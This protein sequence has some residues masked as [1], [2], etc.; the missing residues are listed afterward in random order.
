[1][2]NYDSSTQQYQPEGLGQNQEGEEVEFDEADVQGVSTLTKRATGFQRFMKFVL[3]IVGVVAVGCFAVWYLY[4]G[5]KTDDGREKLQSQQLST[6]SSRTIKN[7]GY[8]RILPELSMPKEGD[9]NFKL[10][11][12]QQPEREPTKEPMPDT[13]EEGKD[14][15]QT[16]IVVKEGE[17]P[18]AT[19]TK[20][21]MSVQPQPAPEAKD[22]F[23]VGRESVKT[24]PGAA[25]LPPVVE[26]QAAPSAPSSVMNGTTPYPYQYRQAGGIPGQQAVPPQAEGPKGPSLLDLKRAAPMMGMKPLDVAKQAVQET[27]EEFKPGGNPKVGEAATGKFRAMMNGSNLETTVVTRMKNRSLTLE[28]GTFI[29]CILETRMDTSVPGMTACVIPQNVYSM[30]GRTLLIEKGSR[31]LGEYTG[32]VA[33]GLERIFVLWTEVRTPNGMIVSLGS[34]STDM[35]G[36]AGMGG[37]VDFHWWKRFGNALLFSIVSDAFDFATEKAKSG[38]NN[39]YYSNTSDNMDTII[40]EA[41]KQAGNIPPTLYKNQGERVG[42]FVARDIDFSGVYELNPRP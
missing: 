7:V 10:E 24:A 12:G 15:T 3:G 20:P 18:E 28:K 14:G 13:K 19:L 9:Q 11:P 17:K 26:R 25:V 22:D 29:D 39:S 33:N 34:P 35:L 42:I 40:E 21:D 6:T 8:S 16:I 1:M 30:D 41:M 5:G 4:F 2:S 38:D 23:P 31:A 37:Y 32:S 36:G 27:V